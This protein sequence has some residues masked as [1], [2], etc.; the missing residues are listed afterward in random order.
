MSKR[1]VQPKKQ[2][3]AFSAAFTP[4]MKERWKVARKA[5]P[6]ADEPI[7]RQ[8]EVE[9]RQLSGYTLQLFAYLSKRLLHGYTINVKLIQALPPDAQKII[10]D[11]Q[12]VPQQKR[13]RLLK[14]KL[15]AFD[16]DQR[17]CIGRAVL[18]AA[19]SDQPPKSSLSLE[20]VAAQIEGVRW[21]W[22][23]WIP[24]G[25]VTVVIA[26]PGVGKSA[27]VLGGI[28]PAIVMRQ[29]FLDDQGGLQ[30]RRKV[31]WI[32]TEAAHAMTVERAK[33]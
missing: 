19:D 1:T 7:V 24:Y 13:A 32:D 3:K 22:K 33:Q 14:D 15:L 10:V 2:H 12:D 20:D 9:P 29:R 31:I 6:Y 21:L 18:V 11:L 30:T 16:E 4:E 28:V 8:R 17:N 26:E 5:R 25:M 27:F 23:C